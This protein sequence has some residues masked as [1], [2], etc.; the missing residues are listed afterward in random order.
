MGACYPRF[1][2]LLFLQK[3]VVPTGLG[4]SGQR[5]GAGLSLATRQGER[6]EGA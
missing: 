6:S 3:G 2:R 4:L 5:A 1:P